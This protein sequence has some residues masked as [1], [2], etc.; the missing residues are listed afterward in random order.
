MKIV[1]TALSGIRAKR[2]LGGVQ[3]FALARVHIVMYR[4][5]AS[6]IA[7]AVCVAEYPAYIAVTLSFSANLL[8]NLTFVVFLTTFQKI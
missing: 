6:V 2:L 8:V 3:L 5:T 1:L 4:V 7:V